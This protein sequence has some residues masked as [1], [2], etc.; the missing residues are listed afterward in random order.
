MG[1]G[2]MCVNTRTGALSQT[3]ERLLE[4]MRLRRK[5]K[6]EDEEEVKTG[7]V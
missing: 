1:K 7:S 5:E 3:E 4:I 2:Y 6:G